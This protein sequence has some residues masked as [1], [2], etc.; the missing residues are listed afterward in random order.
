MDNLL[1]I[2]FEIGHDSFQF[3]QLSNVSLGRKATSF[4]RLD[5]RTYA[6]SARLTHQSWKFTL[7]HT[8]FA[9]AISGSLWWIML[10]LTNLSHCLWYAYAYIACSI[11]QSPSW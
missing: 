11:Q 6:K 10:L 1:H 8:H 7:W 2:N 5:D 3:T 9:L 4:S